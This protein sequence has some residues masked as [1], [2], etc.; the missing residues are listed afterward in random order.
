MNPI[1]MG[2]VKPL[3]YYILFHRICNV[4]HEHDLPHYPTDGWLARILA[5]HKLY[6]RAGLGNL[7]PGLTFQ[8][9]WR[10]EHELD[11]QL[12]THTNPYNHEYI[13]Y[14]HWPY[15]IAFNAQKEAVMFLQIKED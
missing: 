5:E 1:I 11:D 6:G 10:S 8:Y 7:I 9:A 15:V 4:E 3:R 14:I 12:K 13:T 2:K